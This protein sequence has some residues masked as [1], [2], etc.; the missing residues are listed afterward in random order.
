MPTLGNRRPCRTATARGAR[1]A[2]RGALVD[3]A[4]RGK[5]ELVRLHRCALPPE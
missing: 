3:R 4:R 2:A 1:E 5:A